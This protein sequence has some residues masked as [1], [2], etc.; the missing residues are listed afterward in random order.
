MSG[1]RRGDVDARIPGHV[2]RPVVAELAQARDLRRRASRRAPAG[3][4]RPRPTGRPRHAPPGRRCRRPAAPRARL[5]ACATHRPGNRGSRPGSRPSRRGAS[6]AGSCR[7]PRCAEGGGVGLGG[8]QEVGGDVEHVVDARA[9][10]RPA[11][12]VARQTARRLRW[13]RRRRTQAV[14]QRRCSTGSGSSTCT[15]AA[16]SASTSAIRKP[17]D[18]PASSTRACGIR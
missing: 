4:A 3:C 10:W 11:G 2:E 8:V 18:A 12:A 9:G 16:P 7:S 15:C 13:Q 5:P 6:A 1:P 14:A 17:P